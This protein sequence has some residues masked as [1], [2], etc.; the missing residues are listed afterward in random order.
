MDLI[1]ILKNSADFEIV[2]KGG[3]RFLYKLGESNLCI[4]SPAPGQL[5]RIIFD[6]MQIECLM[7]QISHSLG[8]NVV[9]FTKLVENQSEEFKYIVLRAKQNKIYSPILLQS[10]IRSAPSTP[11][12]DIPFAQ[13]VLFFNWITG[14]SDQTRENSI[15]TL[16][17]KIYEIDNELAFYKVETT[18]EHWL[19]K[20]DSFNKT[21]F[22]TNLLDWILHLPEQINLRQEGIPSYIF[23]PARHS[24]LRNLSLLK[25]AISLLRSH[26][27]S[28]TPLSLQ[29][30]LR[31]N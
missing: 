12:L 26:H 18:P 5:T 6:T 29:E 24:L 23:E 10:F 16:D 21:P 8:F 22:E 30:Q 20:E 9:P 25:I 7:F 14:R 2:N 4:K 15:V 19:L 3:H 13:K 27:T 17:G 11:L 31:K 1:N 28:I